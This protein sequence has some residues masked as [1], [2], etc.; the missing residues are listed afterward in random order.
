MASKIKVDQIAGSTGSTV[1]VPT[2]QTLTV[3]DGIAPSSLQT[4]TETKG[5]TG[6]TAY[7]QGDILYASATN[8]LAKLPKGAAG[9]TLTMNSGGTLP[10]WS[11]GGGGGS[12]EKISSGTVSSGNAIVW[13]NIF[14]NTDGYVRYLLYVDDLY[15]THNGQIRCRYRMTDVDASSTTTDA[16]RRYKGFWNGTFEYPD[17]SN[18]QIIY[19]TSNGNGYQFGAAMEANSQNMGNDYNPNASGGTTRGN[20]N[21]YIEFGGASSNNIYWLRKAADEAIWMKFEFLNPGDTNNL[22]KMCNYNVSGH[23][24]GTVNG[25]PSLY[26]NFANSNNNRKSPFI[27]REEGFF[28]RYSDDLTSIN[29][30]TGFTI[31]CNSG[32]HSF[33]GGTWVLYGIKK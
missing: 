26:D 16:D 24:T 28:S 20:Q 3:T 17:T 11:A 23:Y 7:T 21:T 29:K 9:T 32:S 18:P 33:S 14:N 13:D 4:V 10:E 22:Y 30:L 31:Y 27:S 12:M 1:T 19:N 5:G 15:G 8:T 2:G 25:Q 6:Q